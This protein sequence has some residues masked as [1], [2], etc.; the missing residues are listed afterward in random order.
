IISFLL[1]LSSSAQ[2]FDEY[3][4]Y[5]KTFEFTGVY[6]T[7]SNEEASFL[8][9]FIEKYSISSVKKT[10]RLPDRELANYYTYTFKTTAWRDS[11]LLHSAE[12]NW[13]D[14]AEKIPIYFTSYVPNDLHPAQW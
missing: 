8:I 4:L 2:E 12:M 13:V 11:F 3:S 7:S 6:D 5:V 14:F 1:T 10:F 9:P